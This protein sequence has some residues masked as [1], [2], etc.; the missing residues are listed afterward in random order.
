MMKVD[1]TKLKF[2]LTQ[3]QDDLFKNIIKYFIHIDKVVEGKYYILKKDKVI[4][5]MLCVHLDTI[6]THSKYGDKLPEKDIIDFGDGFMLKPT[7]KYSCLG[8]D[9]RAG[10]YM[11]MDYYEQLLDKYHIGI[12]CDEEIGGAGSSELLE[13]T[14]VSCFIGL[15]REGSME[16]ATYGYNNAELIDIFVSRG[17]K[18]TRGTFTD[19]SVLAGLH[20]KPCINLSVGYYNQHRENEYVLFEDMEKTLNHILD[21][22]LVF[23]E[24]Y[25]IEINKQYNIYM[26][27]FMYDDYSSS[28]DDDVGLW[29]DTM[30]KCYHCEQTVNDGNLNNELVWGCCPHCFTALV[31]TSEDF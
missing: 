7:T 3:S 28:F 5:P 14:D 8:A 20:N 19:A 15:D 29:N 9:D 30:T 21:V 18:K 1:K 31:D 25:P 12:F 26:N 24:D 13:L 23:K 27:D 6:N 16:V 22:D 4:K 10:V 2:I 17:F 11:I